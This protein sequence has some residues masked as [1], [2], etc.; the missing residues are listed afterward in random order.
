M[1][2]DDQESKSLNESKCTY[3]KKHI[4]AWKISALQKSEYCQQHQISYASMMYWQKKFKEEVV[5]P[6]VAVKLKEEIV[7][8]NHD[9]LCTLLL[10]GGAVLK[11]HHEKAL[12]TLLSSWR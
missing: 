11:V 9:A 1:K 12:L 10:P 6:L 4:S 8:K 5:S 2:T 7:D 3:W